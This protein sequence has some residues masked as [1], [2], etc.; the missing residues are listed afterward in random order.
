[1]TFPTTFPFAFPGGAYE[2]IAGYETIAGT[3]LAWVPD[4][5]DLG[6][7]L[8]LWQF[9]DKPRLEA[10]LRGL[11]D[12]VQDLDD[13]VW[14]VMTERWLDTAIGE[15]LDGL[16]QIVDLA[17]TGWADET[18]RALLRAQVLVLRSSGTWRDL[19]G[20]LDVLGLT[21]T[22]VRTAEPGIATFQIAIGEPL[23]RDI[24]ADD[25]YRLLERAKPA[26]VRFTFI[27]P[28]TSIATSFTLASNDAVEAS[29]ALG[30]GDAVAAGVGG[31]LAGLLA[32]TETT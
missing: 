9:R 8:L 21:L 16:G 14:A 19:L 28:T 13:G 30:L 4:H 11:L 12:G 10:L 20:I 23:D 29:D 26:G 5:G 25:V 15:Q 22:L 7:E 31:Y 32:T 1:V 24:A 6:V 18:Y 17:R 27:Y 2:P 3:S